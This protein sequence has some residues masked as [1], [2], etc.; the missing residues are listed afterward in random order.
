ML[1]TVQEAIQRI[2]AAGVWL[3]VDGQGV[4]RIRDS[5]GAQPE[6][7]VFAINSIEKLG[8]LALEYLKERQNAKPACIDAGHC[9]FWP[10]CEYFPVQPGICRAR[11]PDKSKETDSPRRRGKSSAKDR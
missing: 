3:W 9:R 8:Q 1:P 10:H 5:T 6:N 7:I 4:I 2:E 11:S